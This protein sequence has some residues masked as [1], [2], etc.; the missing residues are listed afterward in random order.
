MYF[1][2][3]QSNMFLLKHPS[4]SRESNNQVTEIHTSVI[5][6]SLQKY[7]QVSS[8][9]HHTPFFIYQKYSPMNISYK[10][11]IHD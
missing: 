4:T 3:K 10:T 8:P 2:L 1:Q 11:K 7:N 9:H 5:Q 6:L